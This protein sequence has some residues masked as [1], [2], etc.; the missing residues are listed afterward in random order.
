MKAEG[1]RWK[2]KP[3]LLQGGLDD[4]LPSMVTQEQM[5]LN[6][7]NKCVS[8]ESWVWTVCSYTAT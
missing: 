6:M 4:G 3:M 1:G 7:S 8:G 2:A 5:A